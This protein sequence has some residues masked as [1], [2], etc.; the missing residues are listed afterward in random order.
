MKKQTSQIQNNLFL[1]MENL[2]KEIINKLIKIFQ[3]F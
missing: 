1:L 2:E 3:I